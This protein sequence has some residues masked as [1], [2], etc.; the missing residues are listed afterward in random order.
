M[1]VVDKIHGGAAASAKGCTCV[2][3]ILPAVELIVVFE[4]DI[5]AIIL[6]LEQQTVGLEI[7]ALDA[8]DVA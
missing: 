6:Y 1:D 8:G 7:A 4:G 2:D 3:V 5:I